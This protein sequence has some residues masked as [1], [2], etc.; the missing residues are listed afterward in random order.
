VSDVSPPAGA[1][2][3]LVALEVEPGRVEQIISTQVFSFIS[4]TAA[5]G[6]GAAA[7]GGEE[8]GASS[9]SSGATLPGSSNGASTSAAAVNTDASG[10]GGVTNAAGVSP[11]EVAGAVADM[12]RAAG[13]PL[14][15]DREQL[16][17]QALAAQQALVE[18]RRALEGE[19]SA[20]EAQES[21][22]DSLR[23]GWQCRVCFS[24]EVDTAFSGC[25][26]MFCS[27]CSRSLSRCAVCRRASQQLK[28][29]K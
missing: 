24:R 25:G 16:L 15:L 14:D 2:A 29:F 18:A 22:L 19:R 21:E 23:T 26:H 10:G 8:Q 13:L 9:S 1:A 6:E 4:S 11:V 28:L 20:R 5:A 12:M 7:G 17:N 27:Q 3:Y